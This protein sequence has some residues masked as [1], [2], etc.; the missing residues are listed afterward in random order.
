MLLFFSMTHHHNFVTFVI[1]SAQF[2]CVTPFTAF[3]RV[4]HCA[5]K[6]KES[7]K[8]QERTERETDS[9]QLKIQS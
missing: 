3:I 1:K 6:C 4:K 2:A 9:L 5:Q 7:C 8:K